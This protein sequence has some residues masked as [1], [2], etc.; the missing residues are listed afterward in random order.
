MTSYE[1]E[2]WIWNEDDFTKMG[3]HD[4]TVYGMKLDGDLVLDL[5]YIFQWNQ[6]EVE[7]FYFTFWVA[8]CTL[9]FHSATDLSFELTQPI[10]GDRWIEIDDID[11]AEH[12]GRKK[13]TI[14]TQQGDISFYAKSFKQLVRRRPTYQLS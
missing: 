3:W 9:I 7:G 8:P 1:L 10:G 5:D 14:I 12:E 4:A 11:L 13:W 2:K 6:P